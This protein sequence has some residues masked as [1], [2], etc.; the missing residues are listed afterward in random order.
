MPVFEKAWPL[1]R[2][3]KKN[4]SGSG[5]EDVLQ[6]ALRGGDGTPETPP[7]RVLHVEHCLVTSGRVALAKGCQWA[8]LPLA[9]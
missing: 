1:D 6:T 3:R 7:A 5:R 2:F 4:S 9:R 8:L